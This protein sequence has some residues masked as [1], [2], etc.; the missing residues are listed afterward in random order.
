MVCL[1]V[2]LRRR[3][4]SRQHEKW[5]AG[6]ETR[7]AN[8]DPFHDEN[9]PP[10]IHSI[11]TIVE[12]DHWNQKGT[13]TP[14][15]SSHSE[16][17]G[18]TKGA[19]LPVYLQGGTF[20]KRHLQSIDIESPTEP[21]KARRSWAPSTPSIYP[22]SLSPEDEPVL[23]IVPNSNQSVTTS[24]PRPPRSRLRG[25]GIR[26]LGSTLP[27]PPESEYSNPTSLISELHSVHILDR[28]PSH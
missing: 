25:R 28:M 20:E 19:I 5:L 8:D 2:Y 15:D 9:L 4:R 6:M 22:D 13:I 12:E 14:E 7:H 27:T 17:F 21:D 1:I 10:V 3:Y 16:N 26:V 24:P 11:H 18:Q 23:N